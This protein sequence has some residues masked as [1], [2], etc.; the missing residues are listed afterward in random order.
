LRL[1]SSK[2]SRAQGLCLPPRRA[3]RLYPIVS[4]SRLPRGALL[5]RPPRSFGWRLDDRFILRGLLWLYR[6]RLLLPSFARRKS[7]DRS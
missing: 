7:A 4:V 2:L 5:R 6:L 1:L 3:P